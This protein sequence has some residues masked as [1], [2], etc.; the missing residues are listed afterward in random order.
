MLRFFRQ[1]RKK[2]LEQQ[3]MKSY[4]FYAVGEIFLV[5]VGILLALQVNNW[6][7]ERKS[8]DLKHN[9]IES[10]TLDLKSDADAL[11]ESIKS[12][13]SLISSIDSLKWI[14]EN[15]ELS[16]EELV[17]IAQYKV[18]ARTLPDVNFK[19]TTF[20]ALIASGNIKLFS[21]EVLREFGVLHDIHD[22]LEKYN[23]GNMDVYKDSFNRYSAHI[24]S[25]Y[26]LIEEGALYKT[27][28]AAIDESDLAFRI[29]NLLGLRHLIHKSKLNR[30]QDILNQTEEL[31]KLLKELEK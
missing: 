21:T 19:R 6:N 27:F 18:E 9:Y 8:A 14:L 7:E 30:Y 22:E 13:D 2:L 12:Y 24:P 5:M 25:S 1:I 17:Y 20:D 28:W 26:N 15:K 29:G 23:S 3:K 4:I 16:R 10:L 31:I 11:R